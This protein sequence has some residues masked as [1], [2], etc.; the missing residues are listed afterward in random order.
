ML[1]P[2]PRVPPWR[3]DRDFE[4]PRSGEE[5]S[6]ESANA[7]RKRIVRER[8]RE[9]FLND[10]STS[11]YIYIHDNRSLSRHP[12]SLS[13]S[14]AYVQPSPWKNITFVGARMFRRGND[15]YVDFTSFAKLFPLPLLANLS[16]PPLLT[17]SFPPAGEA[18]QEGERIADESL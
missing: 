9:R 3:I 1:L 7:S 13:F 12:E 18:G 15:S 16:V 8:E 6:E 2:S 10:A 4:F 11:I 5:R 17:V 14:L